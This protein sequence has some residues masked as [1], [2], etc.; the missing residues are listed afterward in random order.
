M[1]DEIINA[2]DSASTNVTNAIPTNMTNVISANV[3]STV[4]INFDNN[5]VRYQMNCHILSKVLLVIALLFIIV[6]CYH[7]TKHR[8]K[9]KHITTLTI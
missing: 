5:N 4:P 1:C 3:T 6:I 8:S 2:T 9:Q 7:Y